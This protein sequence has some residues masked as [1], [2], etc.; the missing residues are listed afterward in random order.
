M[1]PMQRI[2]R[3]RQSAKDTN[4]LS[5]RELGALQERAEAIATLHDE[6]NCKAAE[7]EK[8]RVALQA[9]MQKHGLTSVEKGAVLANIVTPSGRATTFIHPLTLRKQVP[10]E[11][12][13]IDCLS[14]SITQVKKY[15]GTKEIAAISQTTPA[16]PG[17]PVLKVER[18]KIKGL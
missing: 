3:V 14:V 5:L 1:P 4:S 15:L 12:V 6:I 11:K 16:V 13:W 10:S 9:D 8:L 7:A 18:R 2:C 17:K